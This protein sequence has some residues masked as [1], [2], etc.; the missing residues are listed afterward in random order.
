MKKSIL[1]VIFFILAFPFFSSA[2]TKDSLRPVPKPIHKNVIKFNP[3]PM[4][5]WSS[6]N[7]TFSYERVLNPKQSITF[8][9]GYLEFP[10][11]FKDTI[12]NLIAITSREKKGINLSFEY[13]FYL[14]QRNL[15][16][17]PDGLYL[18]PYLSY[19]GYWFK[20]GINVLLTSLDSAGLVKGNFYIFNLG[21][22]LG[23]QF[24]FWKRLTLDFVLIGPCMSYYGGAVDITGNINFEQLQDINEDLYNKLKEKYPKIGDFVVNKSFQQ[25]G[26]LDLFS[27]G[28]RY[29]IQ[30]GF[31]F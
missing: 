3:T 26:K 15:R 7:V 23:Y 12:A 30:I 16:P 25:N 4:I 1:I 17:I 20:N 10:S 6:K 22:E 5:L 9:A 18:A 14:M 24:V 19:Y 11:L 27:V 2:Q 8:S 28:F 31:H 13:R 29:L 21:V